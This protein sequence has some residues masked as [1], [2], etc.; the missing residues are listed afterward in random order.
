MH[1]SFARRYG[2]RAAV[3][4]AA[5][6]LGA[7]FAER[8]AAAGIDVT[9]IDRDPGALGENARRLRSAFP[10]R[11]F[12]ELVC[13]LADRS[14]VQRALGE[15]SVQGIGLFVACAAHSGVGAWLEV[16]LEEKLRQ[17]EVNCVS[18][19]TMVDVISRDMAGRGRGGIVIVSSMAGRQGTPLVATYAATK[20]FDLILAES[21]WAELR[22]HGVD[23]VGLMPG[24]TRTPGFEG[25]LPPGATPPKGVRIMEPGEVVQEALEALGKRPSLIAGGWN[26]A[27]ATV[28]Q[29][30]LPRRAA[31]EVMSR[32]MRSMYRRDRG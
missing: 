19:A 23:V 22:R 26:R 11:G 9:L 21:L 2:P 31:I 12:T 1:T 29:R 14:Q 17:I 5:M 10:S 32:S 8:I 4:G 13:D 18:V 15:I 20:A 6:G 3:T 28:M 25:S 7:S 27:A 30:L 24:T 16:P